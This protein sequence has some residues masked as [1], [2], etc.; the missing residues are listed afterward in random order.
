MN[1]PPDKLIV[2]K[3][4]RKKTFSYK[5]DNDNFGS[6]STTSNLAN[7]P[8][9]L[10]Q[11]D[12]FQKNTK[13]EKTDYI[14]LNKRPHFS[15]KIALKE[16]KKLAT[17]TFL[18]FNLG[19]VNNLFSDLITINKCN[20]TQSC[21]LLHQIQK[22]FYKI[23]EEE[24]KHTLSKQTDLLKYLDFS[25]INFDHLELLFKNKVQDAQDNKITSNIEYFLLNPSVFLRKCKFLDLSWSERIVAL[26]FLV[27]KNYFL[28]PVKC[29]C[30]DKPLLA[31]R[32]KSTKRKHEL[33]RFCMKK[34]LHFI[35]HDYIKET[36]ENMLLSK[37]K[38]LFFD[39][40]NE[41]IP[42]TTS[43]DLIKSYFN[44]G[45]LKK[46]RKKRRRVK[47]IQGLITKLQNN[48]YTR[49]YFDPDALKANFFK[50]Y[51]N[52]YPERR[53]KVKKIIERFAQCPSKQILSKGCEMLRNKRI[54]LFFSH[55]D[56]KEGIH[57]INQILIKQV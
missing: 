33:I 21:F 17:E 19:S 3:V 12:I 45:R 9:N 14:I 20:D 30:G 40:L 26:F 24:L 48:A 52:Y 36:D 2:P 51:Q 34:Y 8:K 43:N 55:E 1:G 46:K 4:S 29:F 44:E 13:H 38:E 53:S 10:N 7:K 22:Y 18:A 25:D 15:S 11:N 32:K 41:S 6:F 27:K 42:G 56:I 28:A 5:K 16:S 47:N 35:M 23:W 49:A 54:K 37:K 57:Q 50:V 31:L 39:M